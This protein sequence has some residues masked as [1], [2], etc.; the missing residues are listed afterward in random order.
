[1]TTAEMSGTM[2]RVPWWLILV[3][4]ILSIIVGLALLAWPAKAFTTLVF[5]LGFWWLID[6]IFDIVSIFI[7][8]S[9]WGWK[10]FMGI[11][12]IIAGIF[13]IQSPLQGALVLAPT[14]VIILGFMGI[15]YG[16]LGLV[17]G[18][19]GGGW[20]AAVMGAIS[21]LF[22]L[23]L[24]LN[25]WSASLAIP[26]VFGGFAIVGGIMAIVLAFRVK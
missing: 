4:G 12:G 23:F 8:H 6:G 5:F 22:G 9:R 18:F 13:L 17:N 15:M 3:E 2:K 11:I 20:G 10:L 24:L 7:D 26:W 19:Q 16:V 14:F 25:V 21:I 1:M